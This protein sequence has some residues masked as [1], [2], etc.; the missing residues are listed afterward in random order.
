[1]TPKFLDVY[2]IK[3]V[4]ARMDDDSFQ[5]LLRWHSPC[6]WKHQPYVHTR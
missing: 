6:D 1:M 2:L 4:E 3:P 5:F